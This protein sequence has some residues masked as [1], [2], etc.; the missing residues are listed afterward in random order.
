MKSIQ[1]GQITEEIK[2][3]IASHQEELKNASQAAATNSSALEKKLEFLNADGDPDDVEYQDAVKQLEEEHKALEVS[4]RLLTELFSSLQE[5]T[6]KATGVTDNS[7]H[8]TFG[9]YNSGVQSSVNH[10]TINFTPK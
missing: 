2:K 4:Q 8:T 3:L 10:G 9:A 7:V 6:R 5:S 1:Q